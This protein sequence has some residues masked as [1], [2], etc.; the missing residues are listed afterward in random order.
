MS[1]YFYHVADNVMPLAGDLENDGNYVFR[2]NVYETAN[3][4]HRYGIQSFPL[5]MQFNQFVYL[6]VEVMTTMP[7]QYIFT[8]RCWATPNADP[9]RFAPPNVAWPLAA[10][11]SGGLVVPAWYTNLS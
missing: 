3:Y 6:G 5:T 4:N 8:E 10:P 7:H 9:L 1:N 2:L 11:F